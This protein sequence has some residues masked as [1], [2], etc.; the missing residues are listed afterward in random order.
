[1]KNKTKKL[2]LEMQCLVACL[3]SPPEFD[4][5]EKDIQSRAFDWEH[6]AY[7]AQQ[8]RVAS[9]VFKTLN[10]LTSSTQALAQQHMGKALKQLPMRQLLLTGE[11]VQINRQLNANNIRL[12]ALK[13]I[14]QGLLIN[15]EYYTRHPGNDI[16]I[17]VKEE[18]L[19]KT[20]QRLNQLGYEKITHG[21]ELTA[22]QWRHF[23][24]TYYDEHFWHPRKKIHLE[25]HWRLDNLSEGICNPSFEEAWSRRQT[26]QLASE[27]IA[28]LGQMDNLYY[29]SYHAAKHGWHRLFWLMDI[30]KTLEKASPQQW[31]EITSSITSSSCQRPILQGLNMAYTLF[32]ME[33][34]KVLHQPS[35]QWTIQHSVDS[36]YYHMSHACEHTPRMYKNF[37]TRWITLPSITFKLRL[38][39]QPMMDRRDWQIIQLPD[40]L[41][42]IYYLLR[43]FTWGLRKLG[44]LPNG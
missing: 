20:F 29:L 5:I 4:N 25:L 17:W 43:P 37:I 32:G 40:N 41:F 22:K 15:D 11:L 39:K 8:H 44:L 30:V 24:K 9:S 23:K 10:L 18:E 3:Q 35:A 28:T 27:N 12:I 36:A 31:S 2:S 1:M 13:G 7:L 14:A 19:S 16:D 6:F 26:V 42:F 34:P 21:H 38:L 33:I